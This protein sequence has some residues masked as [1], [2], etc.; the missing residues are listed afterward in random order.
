[1]YEK[2][3]IWLVKSFISIGLLVF[4]FGPPLASHIFGIEFSAKYNAFRL[5]NSLEYEPVFETEH[6][7]IK[8][9]KDIVAVYVPSI[10]AIRNNVSRIGNRVDEMEGRALNKSA[11]F[12]QKPIESTNQPPGSMSF[13]PRNDQMPSPSGFSVIVNPNQDQRDEETEPQPQPARPT[14]K[15][16]RAHV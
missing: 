14:T 13:T 8:E 6:I 1:M 4:S 3:Q 9:L 15:I 7:G 10:E 5:K 11:K 16:G 2:F 12:P